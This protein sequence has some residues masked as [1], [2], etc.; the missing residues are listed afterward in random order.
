MKHPLSRDRL[1]YGFSFWFETFF[2]LINSPNNLMMELINEN[3]LLNDI[4]SNGMKLNWNALIKSTV[5]YLLRT[6]FLTFVMC[7]G[8]FHRHRTNN[9][10][11]CPSCFLPSVTLYQI[12]YFSFNHTHFNLPSDWTVDVNRDHRRSV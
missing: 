10:D 11:T 4:N 3:E 12:T 6:S 8:H 1:C 7:N 5:D 2:F 9:K